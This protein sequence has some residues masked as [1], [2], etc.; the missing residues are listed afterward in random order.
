M[1]RCENSLGVNAGLIFTMHRTRLMLSLAFDVVDE[2][3]ALPFLCVRCF[4]DFASAE[5]TRGAAPLTPAAFVKA[6]ETF[7]FLRF[8]KKADALLNVR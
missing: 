2:F 3:D 1:R 4:G 6:G 8:A 5:A 7:I